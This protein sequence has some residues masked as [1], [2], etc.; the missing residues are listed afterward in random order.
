MYYWVLFVR[1][2]L[3]YRIVFI[4]FRRNWL[5]IEFSKLISLVKVKIVFFLDILVFRVFRLWDRV[6]YIKVMYFISIC[7]WLFFF[8]FLISIIVFII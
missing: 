6:D 1:F 5:R 7:F 4:F 2:G 3:L 8:L